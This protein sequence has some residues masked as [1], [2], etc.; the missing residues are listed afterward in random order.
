MHPNGEFYMVQEGDTMWKIVN[1]M[2][3][4]N[5]TVLFPLGCYLRSDGYYDIVEDWFDPEEL[6]DD[7]D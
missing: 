4:G 7:E 5:L 2:K 1:M 3:Y 6:Y